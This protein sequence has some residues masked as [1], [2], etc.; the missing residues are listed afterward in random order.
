MRGNAGTPADT[1]SDETDLDQ[2]D[3]EAMLL[4][5]RI[6]EIMGRADQPAKQIVDRAGA[7][8]VVRPVRFG[9]I[10]ILLRAMRFKAD[11]Y[12]AVLRRMSI[13]VYTESASG[14][15]EA[16][17]VNDI[18]SLL[19]V[20]DN[21]RQDI[22][23]AALLRSPI[24]GLDRAEE[25]LARIRQAYQGD[26]PV[27]FH[28]AVQKY[29][30][31]KT[32]DLALFLRNFREKLR[33]WRQ[34]SR[35][36]PVA[37]VLWNIYDQTGYLAYVTGLPNGQQ[38]QANL[39]ELH[40]RATQFG[41]FERQGLGRFLAFLEK[42]KQETDLGQASIASQAEDVVRIMTVHRSKGQEFPVVLLP[43]LGK[44]IN[45]RD[46]Q[47]T[48]LLDRAA[49]LG[50]QVVDPIRQIR[51]PSLAFTV[52]QQRLRQQALA[53]ELRVLYVAMTR[54]KE[55]LILAGSCTDKQAADWSQQWLG[56]HGPMPT[57]MILGA[58]APLDW[59][60][61]VASLLPSQFNV[62][63]YTPD[64]LAGWAGAHS[65]PP[66]LTPQ[67]TSQALGQPLDPA[68]LLSEEARQLIARLTAVYPHQAVA[69]LAAS[70]SVTSLVKNSVQLS[71]SSV[72]SNTGDSPLAQPQF[73]VGEL[74]PNAADKGT[75]IHAVL[76][77]FDFAQGTDSI[78]A[79]IK[80]LIDTRRLTD[81]QAAL[82]D[83]SA[84]EWFLESDIGKLIR[85]NA[86]R[87]HRELPIYYANLSETTESTEPLDQQMIRGRIDLLVPVE[88]GWMIVDYKTD[89]VSGTA[90][91]DRA[92]LYT[93]QLDLYRKA[94][95]KITSRPVV[96]SALVF[97]TRA[98][99]GWSDS[100]RLLKIGTGGNAA[101]ISRSKA[102]QLPATMTDAAAL[103]ALTALPS[104]ARCRSS[105]AS[106][107]GTSTFKISPST[108]I[109]DIVASIRSIL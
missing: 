63:Q 52:V 42:L 11:Q 39:T 56:H 104:I 57:E 76:E 85:D 21:Q 61:P 13:P 10:V 44:A 108:R 102:D 80:H 103:V 101:G 109:C 65:T 91:D 38:R 20:L 53:E 47:G 70:A 14:Y 36:R 24:A 69:H 88:G 79:Q 82:V 48:I 26:P 8:P 68:P 5:K 6:L 58:K 55:H 89:R 34:D 99:S 50:F 12:A 93:A 71:T 30:D 81:A 84:L 59:L 32:D 46:C 35:Q 105:C 2:V 62:Q 28:L 25:K 4:G 90:L 23:L 83:M 100:I 95:H 22:P 67:Q 45:L 107:I 73:L 29:A 94:V 17:E 106:L 92:A 96:N 78:S 40:D 27:P 15:F 72:A 51:Y 33:V 66:E 18:L 87:L 75:A 64:E 43:D 60:A 98:R 3:R 49:G 37:E 19:A 1:D 54:A 74:P 31:E 16:T 7:H 9:D 77:H 97:L 86:N 41:S